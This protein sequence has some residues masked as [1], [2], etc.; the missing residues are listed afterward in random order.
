MSDLERRTLSPGRHPALLLVDLC[1]GF[2]DS[3]SPLGCPA[4]G[5]VLSCQ[6]LLDFFRDRGWPRL[7]T[8]IIYRH[9]TE[10]SVFRYRLP[11]LNILT[12]DSKWVKIDS[13]LAR[14]DDEPLIE[15]N[16]PSMFFATDLASR[17][18]AAGCDSLLVT[19][20]TTSGCVRATVLD[21]LQYNY[22]VFIPAEATGD[23]N[24][25]AHAANLFDLHAKY[26]DVIPIDEILEKLQQLP[27]TG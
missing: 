3:R 23:R 2:T 24:P 15:R 5:V 14:R 22:P 20:L 11:A 17:L 26:A 9:S 25:A 21:G 10:A 8:T 16:F 4:D 12:P 1:R 27:S 6:R 13:R 19:G 18:Q 7:F